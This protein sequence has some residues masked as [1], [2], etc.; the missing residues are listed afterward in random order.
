[1]NAPTI[2]SCT[3]MAT[4]GA[5]TVLAVSGERYCLVSEDGLTWDKVWLSGTCP[6]NAVWVG[7]VVQRFFLV[8]SNSAYMSSDGYSW[9]QRHVD[10]PGTLVT[11]VGAI[12][13]YLVAATSAGV[14]A[15]LAGSMWRD[16]WRKSSLIFL[17][18][19]DRQ[20]IAIDSSENLYLGFR[21]DR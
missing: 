15:S 19:Q 2:P 21:T 9:S 8:G 18:A 13:R 7:G 3:S 10:A 6:S 16:R 20:V 12:G 11:K 1:L 5:R 17:A 14:A 4:N